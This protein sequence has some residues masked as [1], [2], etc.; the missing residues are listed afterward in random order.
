MLVLAGGFAAFLVLTWV[1]RGAPIGQAAA[2]EPDDAPSSGKR[3][4]AV[5]QAVVAF[6]LIA[7]GAVVALR[8]GIP[9][10]LPLFAL[11]IG[12]T[13]WVQKAYR[14]YRHVSPTLRRVVAFSEAGLTTALVGGIL[15]VA[16]V[17]AFRYGGRPLDFTQ[18]RAFTLS[19]LS[20]Q[21]ARSLPKPLRFTLVMGQDPRS[22]R[23]RARVRQ[24]VQL[25]KDA[26]PS[27]V[28]VEE[29]HPYRQAHAAT[30]AELLK[31]APDLNVIPGDAI[32]LEYGAEGQGPVGR[33]VI[34]AADLTRIEPSGMSATFTGEDAITSTIARLRE[35][36]R[37][38]IGFVAGHGEPSLGETDPR[39]PGL[40]LWKT[41]LASLGLDA[42]ELNLARDEVSPAI[43]AV[44]IVAP[45]S[46]Y[47]ELEVARLRA[48]L[49]NGGALMVISDRQ[50]VGLDAI[51]AQFNVAFDR[52]TIVDP[53]NAGY[54]TE[55]Y[56]ETT[57][58]AD[59]PPSLYGPGRGSGSSSRRPH[60]C[61]SSARAPRSPAS[62]K[63]RPTRRWN[64]SRFSG[65]AGP[66]GRCSTGRRTASS[67]TAPTTRSGRW[68]SAWPSRSARR[69]RPRGR[70]GRGRSSSPAPWRPRTR[71]SPMT[72]T[73]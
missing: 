24:V 6:L 41:R 23:Q 52:G 20:L 30:Y 29:I 53:V 72:P 54:P 37:S 70:R 5:V 1:V 39:L 44:V 50:E 59:H 2:A 55:V 60:R 8:Y 13:L 4:V 10:S 42:V 16:I 38:P 43:G 32:V 33:S 69:S 25:Y 48:F 31:R 56:T 3:D 51:L 22:I 73:C 68:S 64:H 47:T 17:A 11:G 62:F 28:S 19:S 71:S 49:V 40:G 35:G 18:D 12:G 7:A 26:N 61:T 63:P 14:P 46:P 9:W 66:R 36:K 45:R 67:P 27:M 15:L 58:R 34:S 57:R 21:E 65:R